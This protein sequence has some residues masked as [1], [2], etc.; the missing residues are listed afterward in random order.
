MAKSLSAE[1]VDVRRLGSVAALL[2]ELI[3]AQS[4]ASAAS[5]APPS[6]HDVKAADLLNFGRFM[7]H[8]NSPQ[9]SSSFDICTLGNDA[10]SHGIRDVAAHQTIND[11]QVHIRQLPDVTD[12]RGCSIIYISKTESDNIREDLAI[13]GASEILTVSDADGFLER[14]GMIQFLLVENHVRFA[15]NLIAV[16][17]AHLVLSSELLRVAYSVIGKPPTEGQP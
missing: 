11:L 5:P 17:R 16:N 8:S 7:R 3:L 2:A 15:V 14:G 10:T 9:P 6:Q 12:A 13:L 1:R 4:L